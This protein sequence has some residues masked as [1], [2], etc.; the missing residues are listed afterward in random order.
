MYSFEVLTLFATLI[1]GPIQ[2][3][4]NGKYVELK[5]NVLYNTSDN[6]E[7]KYPRIRIKRDE[8]SINM[9]PSIDPESVQITSDSIKVKVSPEVRAIISK[10]LPEEAIKEAFLKEKQHA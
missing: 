2:S 9:I 8:Y 10:N 1:S 5:R 4:N 3:T 6:I 7:R